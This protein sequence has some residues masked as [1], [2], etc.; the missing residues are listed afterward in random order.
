MKSKSVGF[1]SDIVFSMAKAFGAV[2]FSTLDM[3]EKLQAL[4][5]DDWKQGVER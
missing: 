5:P 1:S 4:A 3:A 2:K